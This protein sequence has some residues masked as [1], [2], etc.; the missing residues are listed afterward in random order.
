MLEFLSG[1]AVKKMVES[2]KEK[3]NSPYKDLSERE[4]AKEKIREKITG[5]K[6]TKERA[7]EIKDKG[8]LKQRKTLEI[9]NTFKDA[10]DLKKTLS[11]TP[12]IEGAIKTA[13]G[14]PTGLKGLKGGLWSAAVLNLAAPKLL[15][16]AN[17]S[18]F[19]KVFFK[20]NEKKFFR[21]LRENYE[22]NYAPYS[23]IVDYG[24]ILGLRYL[25]AAKK[26]GNTILTK[27]VQGELKAEEE[28]TKAF[29]LNRLKKAIEYTGGKADIKS[30]SELSEETFKHME[31]M[32][33]PDLPKET[34]VTEIPKVSKFS[35]YNPFSYLK[36]NTLLGKVLPV[37]GAG[38]NA[39]IANEYRKQ[40]DVV[41][42]KLRIAQVGTSVAEASPIG[43]FA[44]VASLGLEATDDILNAMSG[45][46]VRKKQYFAAVLTGSVDTTFPELFGLPAPPESATFKP[47]YTKKGKTLTGQ[48]LPFGTAY[49]KSTP[50]SFEQIKKELKDEKVPLGD[51]SFPTY[52]LFETPSEKPNKTYKKLEFKPKGD[53]PAITP[54]PTI[55]IQ[56]KP[57]S[58]F[59]PL[60][61]DIENLGNI[62]KKQTSYQPSVFREETIKPQINSSSVGED[63]FKKTIAFDVGSKDF[64]N[65]KMLF[66]LKE[67]LVDALKQS[68]SSAYVDNSVSISGNSSG[69]NDSYTSSQRGDPIN[70]MRSDLRYKLNKLV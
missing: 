17:T 70:H 4:A 62:S 47:L 8:T 24:S 21:D 37:A 41:G 14:V 2:N 61:L 56:K 64:L 13:S 5:K 50:E 42:T 20:E 35:K 39:Y 57:E 6:L 9:E 19:A 28:A 52:D 60:D 46:D 51:K 33:L 12:V 63:L 55:E 15:D 65:E 53:V 43:E 58:T 34:P 3:K 59:K 18:D 54:K 16:L 67:S 31:D 38:I 11:K 40:G 26:S 48:I 45:G 23:P 32:H 29:R 30:L 68:Q 66:S 44:A 22:T 69:G 25:E 36:N 7:D 49:N 10:S 27:E 1:Y